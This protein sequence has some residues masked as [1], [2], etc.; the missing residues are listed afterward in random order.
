MREVR[1]VILLPLVLL[2]NKIKI[3]YLIAKKILKNKN[4]Y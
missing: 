2:L 1:R 3:V 4:E